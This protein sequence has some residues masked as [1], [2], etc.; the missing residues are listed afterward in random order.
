MISAEGVS[1]SLAGKKVLDDVTARA[2]DEFVGVVGPNG[3]G[4]TT[5]IRAANGAAEPDDGVVRVDGDEVSSLS[6]R[7]VSRRVATMPQNTDVSFEFT[8]EEVV[9]MGRNPHVPRF[10][11]DT[12][13]V[14]ED[15][16]ERVGV[17]T[18]ADRSVH[19]VSG[20]ERQRVLLA[21]CL[22]QDADV[23]LLDEPTASLDVNHAVE[24][25]SLVRSLVDD[26]R[27]AVAAI[28][29]LDLAARF[30]DRLVLVD[31]GSVVASGGPGDVLTE[32]NVEGV[33][34]TP[35]FVGR[36][37]AT[38][39]VR[40]TALNEK[41]A[42]DGGSRERAHYVGDRAG[43]LRRLGRAY[44]VSVGVVPEGCAAVEA[45]KEGT[46]VVVS[47]SFSPVS[48]EKRE[49]VAELVEEA[50]VV[51]R[52]GA[53]WLPETNA[54]VETPVVSANE[55]DVIEAIEDRDRS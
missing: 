40:V 9:R 48:E 37:P 46:E 45:A 38:G 53:G 34:G 30:C 43:P 54:V 21:R 12:T 55:C 26:G 36:D 13:K 35:A 29:D 8:V 22:A 17:A 11:T 7:E 50:G 28:H 39:A 41:Q 47:E 20:G 2:E 5:L 31:D 51:V 16:M 49:R 4:K 15:A 6:S 24:T 33:F 14:V 52:D 3:A 27:T 32:E 18:F 19:E 25:L 1:V 44:D 23:L 42:A 10:G